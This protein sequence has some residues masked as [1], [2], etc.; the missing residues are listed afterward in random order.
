MA[1]QVVVFCWNSQLIFCIKRANWGTM[2][3]FA[4]E[5]SLVYRHHPV[6]WI[7]TR[8]FRAERYPPAVAHELSI[9]ENGAFNIWLKEMAK[10]ISKLLKSNHIHMDFGER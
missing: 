4:G 1:E 3:M 9:I 8:L 7:H 5:I 10:E 2:A 6:I